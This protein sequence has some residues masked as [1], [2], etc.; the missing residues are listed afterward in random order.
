MDTNHNIKPS[1]IVFLLGAG[2]SVHAGVPD[3]YKFVEFYIEN[4]K[5]LDK[6]NTIKTIVSKLKE[7]K[8]EDIDIELLLESLIKLQNKHLE[9]LLQFYENIEDSFLL[10]DYSENAP[11]IDDLKEFIKSKSIIKNDEDGSIEEKINYLQSFRGFII[12][13]RNERTPIDI[14]SLNY[15]ICIE[16]FCNVYGLKYQ[17][18]FDIYWNP[19]TFH[20]ENIHIRLYKLHGSVMW[21][22]SD[23]GSYIKLPVMEKA[24]KLELYTGEK[25][26]TLILY[27]MQKWE[28]AEPLLELL[29]E[30]K[31]LLE[32]EN[33]KFLIIAGYSF[34]D[35]YIR[36]IILDISTKN[37]EI[38]VILLD[39]V[40]S[41]Q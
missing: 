9:P 41:Q 14:I 19:R 13:S 7:W 10:R 20:A 37:R 30:I 31:H 1:K 34:R 39:P 22:K 12:D 35:E 11:L 8:G 6:K 21:Y 26:E 32:S 38:C 40:V 33:C 15:D 4:I 3:T 27:P 36:K 18:G 28:Y 23:R 29:I 25:A 24:N 2:A 17:D 16:Q 5:D